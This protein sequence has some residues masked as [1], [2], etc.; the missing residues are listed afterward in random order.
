MQQRI[1]A[2]GEDVEYWVHTEAGL[3]QCEPSLSVSSEPK[4]PTA[5]LSEHGDLLSEPWVE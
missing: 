2:G 3:A 5:L 4:P 1:R